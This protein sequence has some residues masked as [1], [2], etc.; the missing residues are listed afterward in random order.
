M[1]LPRTVAGAQERCRCI[2]ET[3][4]L[5]SGYYIYGWRQVPVNIDV[6]GEKAN[7][8][9]P[10]IEQIMIAN[11]KGVTDDEFE[12]ELY[13]IRRRIEKPRRAEQISDFYIC[14]LS[15][16]LGH[17]QGHVPGR[18]GH[19][20]LSGPAGRA[21]RLR[22][23]DLPP[24]LLDQHL[25]DLVAGAAVPHARPQ[26]RDQHA[27]GQPQLDEGHETRMD[28]TVF[29]ELA[30]R[31]SSRSSSRAARTRRALDNVFEVL[32]RAGGSLPMAKSMLVP[33]AWSNS[34]TH[35]AG[36][37]DA[38][39]L[40]QRGDG[41][42]G[43]SGGAGHDRRPLG[44][45]RHGP[46][47]PAADALRRHRRR[48]LI[49]GSE[50]G[51][52]PTDDPRSSRRAGSGPG[53]MIA[54]DM[55]E[56]RLYHDAEI[57]DLLAGDA[58]LR[59]VGRHDHR[60][61]RPGRARR[62][63]RP[64][65]EDELR[66]RQIAAGYRIEELETVLQPMAEDGKEAIGS[67]GDDT[68]LAVLSAQYRGCIHYFRQNF[69]QVTNPPI[70]SL[71]RAPGDDPEDPVRQP[72]QR[73]RRGHQPD[74]DPAARVARVLT[75]EFEAMRAYMGDAGREIDCTFDPSRP[76]A[77]RDALAP[78]PRRG[79]GGGARPARATWC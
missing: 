59:R 4:V 64:L 47:R 13:V 39:R 18:A 11:A 6:I 9:R 53:Q 52:V 50:A 14:S 35:A 32:V 40:L 36:A 49:A 30:S 43:R 61:R 62:R 60:P 56:G 8:T 15:L 5:S 55:G 21:L 1:F 78:H 2:V 38:V 28:P 48:L 24:A 25:P 42:V 41:A 33:E 45:R 69:S 7:A 23:R 34:A 76:D 65:F 63:S 20:L 26:R 79:R 74:A 66:R 51:M 3:E 67:M 46:Q 19:R 16:P 17:L 27:E 75:R 31:T 12:L 57:K 68:P 10:E 22:L 37:Q 58:S 73:A 29:G 54:V 77:L 72:R 71:A 70:D 44:V